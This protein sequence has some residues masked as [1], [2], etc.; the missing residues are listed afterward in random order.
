[1]SCSEVIETKGDYLAAIREGD[2]VAAAKGKCDCGCM[3]DHP[4][5]QLERVDSVTEKV[6]TTSA[7]VY[8]RSTGYNIRGVDA[9]YD[10][11][12]DPNTSLDAMYAL[13]SHKSEV[14]KLR[15]EKAKVGFE[16]LQLGIQIDTIEDELDDLAQKIYE[17]EIDARLQLKT[18]PNT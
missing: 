17:R 8:S 1:M 5:V 10:A 3:Y 2:M 14:L 13:K 18:P 15:A 11:I 12:L 16:S 7:T 6:I 4:S 9:E